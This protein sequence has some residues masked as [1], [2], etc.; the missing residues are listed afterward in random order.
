MYSS[1]K[2]TLISA[3]SVLQASGLLLLLPRGR[4]R[5]PGLNASGRRLPDTL[6]AGL[7]A[8]KSLA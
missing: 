7:E 3:L 5:V 2:K 8:C 1:Y 4:G 6:S